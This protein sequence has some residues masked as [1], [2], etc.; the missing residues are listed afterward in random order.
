MER[1]LTSDRFISFHRNKEDV[2]KFPE[3]KL[4]IGYL[5]EKFIQFLIHLNNNDDSLIIKTLK[6]ITND[7]H[8][9]CEIFQYAIEFKEVAVKIIYH[10]INNTNDEIRINSALA[11]KQFCKLYKSRD[12]IESLSFF[13]KI[14]SVIDD[15]NEFVR[16]Y[17]VEGLI[18][19]VKFRHGKEVLHQHNILEKIIIKVDN[20]KSELILNKFMVL[21][22]E[23]LHVN[24][25]T[26]TAL[27]NNYIQILKK[28]INHVKTKIRISVFINLASLCI[29]EQGKE[30]CTEEGSLIVNSINQ[31][32]E[33]IELIKSSNKPKSFNLID[34]LNMIISLTR[35][36]NT[37]SILK[38]GKVEIFENKGLDL[39]LEL[40]KLVKNEQILINVLEVLG[41]TA[42]EPRARKTLLN[43]L[44]EISI[45]KDF[46]YDIVK[47][48][49]DLT[50]KIITW[51]P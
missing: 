24:E 26:I 10:L 7:L 28:H 39:Y 2:S 36:Q 30:D 44:E 37:V 47:T 27:K 9:G 51:K 19:Y 29:N 40:L 46:D 14:Q 25:A 21:T 32:K 6:E 34:T 22:N 3:D 23:I 38:R 18:E 12:M 43:H 41:N 42:E 33:Q 5:N 49:A 35:F 31:L 13:E 45:F 15:K 20:E 48:Q 50:L 1:F 11:F 16:L 4:N 17:V 8:E